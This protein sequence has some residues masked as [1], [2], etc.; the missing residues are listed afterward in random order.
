MRTR[1]KA[2]S[3][4]S[5][6]AIADFDPA[7]LDKRQTRGREY[8]SKPPLKGGTWKD[9]FSR[10][11]ESSTTSESMERGTSRSLTSEA[12]M[13]TDEG[14]RVT[15]QILES[16]DLAQIGTETTPLPTDRVVPPLVY[17]PTIDQMRERRKDK[18]IKTNP[19]SIT[20][21]SDK[22][23][24]T[25]PKMTAIRD[26][27]DP[28]QRAPLDS[29][30]GLS[31]GQEKGTSTGYA[32]TSR[33][34]SESVRK[35]RETFAEKM[36]RNLDDYEREEIESEE[37]IYQQMTGL[38]EKEMSG[39][40]SALCTEKPLPITP[41]DVEHL[42]FEGWHVPIGGKPLLQN[43]DPPPT[44]WVKKSPF[45]NHKAVIITVP[46]WESKYGSTEYAVDVRFGCIYRVIG[47]HW[48]DIKVDCIHGHLQEALEKGDNDGLGRFCNA[49]YVPVKKSD[50]SSLFKENWHVPIMGSPLLQ[51]LVPPPEYWVQN[52][53]FLGNKA[54]IICLF[55]WRF[56]YGTS[57]F[58]VDLEV[59]DIYRV[60]GKWWKKIPPKCTIYPAP[61]PTQTPQTPQ[62]A[63]RIRYGQDFG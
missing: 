55:Q 22:S 56:K 42:Y 51:N 41:E 21:G 58:G 3:T 52:T 60:C 31:S 47:I 49:T 39:Y 20:T 30:I 54:V 53:P 6:I 24:Q 16:L 38:D 15:N 40:P 44:T 8:P 59:G 29:G 25:R 7:S 9:K 17:V 36:S 14:I 43:L 37:G 32:M 45:L 33:L 10:K 2:R 34:E 23:S 19:G 13:D 4:S 12:A 46:E 5:R 62:Q 18:E 26:L 11:K 63:Q 48:K 28:E 1:S 61:T 35:P 50:Y 57:A 27:R